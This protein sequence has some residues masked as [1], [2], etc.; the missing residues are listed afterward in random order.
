MD[1]P[2]LESKVRIYKVLG[3]NNPDWDK[4]YE[5]EDKGDPEKA[6]YADDEIKKGLRK[7][8]RE[9]SNDALDDMPIEDAYAAFATGSDNAFVDSFSISFKE[10]NTFSND[11]YSIG[12]PDGYSVQKK[13]DRD[14]AA[15]F[16]DPDH[17]KDADMGKVCIY[18]GESFDVN[19]LSELKLPEARAQTAYS[20]CE[21]SRES[22]EVIF[23][24][25]KSVLY[26]GKRT[27]GAYYSVYDTGAIHVMIFIT[28]KTQI[29]LFRL[30]FQNARKSDLKRVTAYV[31]SLLDTFK[32]KERLSVLEPIDSEKNRNAELNE[33]FVAKFKKLLSDTSAQYLTAVKVQTIMEASAAQ[34]GLGNAESVKEKG[35]V[36]LIG[37][38][39]EIHNMEMSAAAVIQAQSKNNPDNLLLLELYDAAMK[40]IGTKKGQ[41]EVIDFSDVRQALKTPE[42]KAL[43]KKQSDDKKRA[44]VLVKQ[45]AE[46]AKKAREDKIAKREAEQ[47]AWVEERDRIEEQIDNEL[48]DAAF[49]YEKQLEKS[50]EEKYIRDKQECQKKIDANEEERR[51]KRAQLEQLGVFKFSEKKNLK[52]YIQSLDQAIA[53]AYERISDIEN[54]YAGRKQVISQKVK[55]FRTAKKKELAEKYPFP[56]DPSAIRRNKLR[57]RIEK[58]IND[59]PKSVKQILA[60]NNIDEIDED[61]VSKILHEMKKA[62]DVYQTYG[63]SYRRIPDHIDKR[64]LMN[65]LYDDLL[66]EKK[67]TLE[68]IAEDAVV[69][70]ANMDNAS[71][72]SILNEMYQRNLISRENWKG[73]NRYQ[74]C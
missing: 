4:D 45:Q 49:D 69:R 60:E 20:F 8:G 23:S 28:L 47:Q 34:S 35:T 61:D 58:T 66:S 71:L 68:Q 65:Y 33:K 74:A 26:T 16:P 56:Q 67:M 32:P 14:F 9:D 48:L 51:K 22:T 55:E 21:L 27:G 17:P 37:L 62:G 6:F 44:K 53:E 46:A 19:G 70:R 13:K 41:K 54:E 40:Q 1:D 30:L 31:N 5:N 18:A 25:V 24:S 15:W 36:H 72:Q 73:Q 2:E 38:A 64:Y 42:I 11:K 12:I 59:E 52:V 39:Q 3:R 50:Y 57:G 63:G 10:N 29:K 43:L 7:N